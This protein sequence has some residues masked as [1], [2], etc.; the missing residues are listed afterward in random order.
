M[1]GERAEP[2]ELPA[3]LPVEAETEAVGVVEPRPAEGVGAEIAQV[4]PTLD[5]PP[6]TPA[7]RQERED[8]VVA[9]F[10]ARGVRAD[11]V[12][13]AG[14]LVPSHHRHALGRDVTG[15][16]VVVGMAQ[17]RCDELD[18]QLALPRVF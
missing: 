15:L 18:P 16:Q 10:P 17:T 6:A 9:H 11:R 1:L 13:D 14:P 12:D 4:G 8:D 7:T 2:A 3:R 5:T